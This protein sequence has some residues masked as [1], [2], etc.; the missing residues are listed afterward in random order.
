MRSRH[1]NIVSHR[2]IGSH[3][4]VANDRSLATGRQSHTVD[5]MLYVTGYQWHVA[6]TG[7]HVHFVRVKLSVKDRQFHVVCGESP[8]WQSHISCSESPG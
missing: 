4:Q 7:R 5:D 6:G 2:L 1:C 8:G 3:W